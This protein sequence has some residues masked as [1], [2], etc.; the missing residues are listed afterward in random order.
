MVL[1]CRF[2]TA[3][4]RGGP[5][6]MPRPIEVQAHDPRR[7]VGDMLAWVHQVRIHV[8]AASSPVDPHVP[9]IGLLCGARPCGEGVL[10]VGLGFG[11]MW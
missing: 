3:L 8:S 5:G 11:L 6:G 1:G 9:G 10:K 7:Y 2:V 4:T